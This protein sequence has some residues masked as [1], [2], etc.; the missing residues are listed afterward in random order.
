MSEFEGSKKPHLLEKDRFGQ[1]IRS[2]LPELF[3]EYAPTA[4]AMFDTEMCYVA[5]SRRWMSDFG[6]GEQDI[7]G[8]S[9][10]DVFPEISER[11]KAIHQRCLQGANER[12]S[13]EP[14]F[15]RVKIAPF[16]K[17][18]SLMVND[19]SCRSIG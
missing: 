4:I 12:E 8:R 17:F 13:A 1:A 16:S 5:V 11:W 2:D 18:L 7:I 10:Y 6:L 3:L 19:S 14:F 9:H 15:V